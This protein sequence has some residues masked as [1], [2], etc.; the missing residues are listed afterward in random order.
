MS[1]ISIR[2]FYMSKYTLFI[3][4]YQKHVDSVDRLVDWE[5]GYLGYLDS[6]TIKRATTGGKRLD[7]YSVFRLSVVR[8]QN[9]C[10]TSHIFIIRHS[11]V[12]SAVDCG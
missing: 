9:C 2:S 8:I 11:T 12:A 7:G 6:K 4:I 5:I 1:M 3:D 10:S